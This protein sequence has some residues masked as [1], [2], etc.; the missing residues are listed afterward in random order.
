MTEM[1]VLRS[2]ISDMCGSVIAATS[3]QGNQVKKST[4]H[5]TCQVVVVPGGDK[6]AG[7]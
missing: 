2:K 4:P 7:L 5:E 3:I 1:K 6:P